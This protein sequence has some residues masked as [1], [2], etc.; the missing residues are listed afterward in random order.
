M[1]KTAAVAFEVRWRKNGDPSDQ[2]SSPVGV[3]ADGHV[4]VPGLERVSD[5]T[6]EA[7]AISGCGAK[8]AWA[9]QTFNLPDKDPGTPNIGDINGNA[10]ALINPQFNNGGANGSISGWTVDGGTWVHQSGTNGPLSGTSSYAYRTGSSGT[11][12]D[13]I[14]NTAK[15][16]VYPGAMVKASCLVR[17]TGSP[18]GSCQVRVSWRDASD[19]ELSVTHGSAV[20]GNVTATSSVSAAAPSGAVI[21]HIEADATSHTTGAYAVDNFTASS[22]A[23]SM[24]QVPDGG[25]RYAAITNPAGQAQQAA[26]I[27]A[28]YLPGQNIVPNSSFALGVPGAL[29]FAWTS[30]GPWVANPPTSALPFATFAQ[31]VITSATPSTTPIYTS[32]LPVLENVAYSLQLQYVIVRTLSAGDFA[33]DIEWYTSAGAFI[34]RTGHLFIAVSDT[35]GAAVSIQALNQ[36]APATAAFARL[37]LY[38]ENAAQTGGLV[39]FKVSRIKIEIGPTCTP[40][41]DDASQ[42]GNQLAAPGSGQTIGDQRNL[43]PVTWAGVRSVLSTSPISYSIATSGT[44]VTFSVAAV[45]V[46][47]GGVNIA[48]SASSGSVTQAA[49][50]TVTYYLYY[51][52]A[53]SAGGSKTLNITTSVQALAAFPDIVLLGS[54]TV[55]V[56]SGGGGSGGTGGGGGGLCVA[57]DM[58]IAEGRRA[59]DVEIGDPFDCIDL[60][61]AAGKHVRALQGLARG[62][63]ECV[64]MITSDGCA[65]VCSVSTPF[66]LPD[67]RLSYARHML[68]EQVV[69][70]L[71]A[72]TVT[73]LALV[74]SLPVT[75]AHLGG[76]SYAAGADPQRRIY[77][78]NGPSKP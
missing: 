33:G 75:R 25:S 67:G 70:D 74:G 51:R 17:G 55:T 16:P 38:S 3:G 10:T 64:R 28:S 24:D 49:G 23:D 36:I 50:T 19:S 76:V 37:R 73:S 22:T 14:R 77:S 69:T 71:G 29:P 61:T 42:F 21:A 58:F 18:N 52:D 1:T 26:Q 43:Q 4:S 7:R 56:A 48:Y 30:S 39:Y 59:G 65:L 47:A 57:D 12:N 68:G 13:A 72:A 62:T 44:T 2:W 5:Y 9:T 41:T 15:F 78:H 34:S 31:I 8:S 35:A 66:D 45:T 54:A 20:T 6:F 60:P 63:E 40:Y 32:Y 27:A 46:N 53:T 11:P